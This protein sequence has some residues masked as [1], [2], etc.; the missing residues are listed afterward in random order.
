VDVYDQLSEET[1]GEGISFPSALVTEFS[2]QISDPISVT[3]VANPVDLPDAKVMQAR[4]VYVV[5]KQLPVNSP[6]FLES[7]LKDFK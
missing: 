2:R 5:R 6:L 7:F 4:I 3:F 1:D